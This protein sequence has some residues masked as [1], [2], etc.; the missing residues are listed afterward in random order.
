MSK[1][2]GSALMLAALALFLILNRGAYKSYFQD[3]DL[4]TMGWARGVSLP[5]FAEYLFSPRLPPA[6]FR[7][8]GALYYHVLET[9]FDLDF[10]KY[11]IPLHALHLLNVWLLWRLI[12]KLGTGTG[13][14]IAGVFFFGFHTTLIDSWWKPMYVFDVLCATFALLA[15]LLYAYDR[16]VLSLI[17][18]WLAYKSKELAVMLPAVIAC[19]ELWFGQKRWRRLLP[20]FA[21]SLLFGVQAL[22]LRS[23]EGTPYQMRLGPGA[24]ATTVAFYSSQL[25]LLP[26]AGLLLI[27]LPLFIRDR[28]LWF[29]L[30]TMCLLVAPLLLLPGRL[31]AVYWYVPLTGVAIMLASVA[32]SRY[33]MAAAVLLVLWIPWDLVHFREMRRANQLRGQQNRAYV[34]A[35]EKFARLN[36]NERLFVYDDLPDQ[37]HDWGVTGALRTIYKNNDIT[38][39]HIGQGG[40]EEL[41]QKGEA[42]WL[43][44]SRRASRLD[45]VRYSRAEPIAPYLTMDIRS[46][47]TQLL[48]GWY[49]LEDDFRWTKPDAAAVLQRPEGAR[50]FEVTACILPEQSGPEHAVSLRV[51]VDAEPIGAHEFNA[52]GCERVRWPLV[53]GHAGVVK[54]EFHSVPPY[55]PPKPDQR[56]LGIIMKGF[57]FPS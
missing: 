36:P 55:A 21:V 18:F 22:M 41:V 44:W 26:F 47:A 16:W 15:L 49:A 1:R 7:P 28:R 48:S 38:A 13:A 10:P 5:V 32:D 11:V 14:A 54:V 56:I 3:D 6:N 2:A 8:V 31:Y 23:H 40:A 57:G 4:D 39:Q 37:F 20:F 19:Y 45:A 29:G 34:Q 33:R 35:I 50:N 53:P 24:Q 25:F 30:A 43:H 9:S 52:A 17:S 51:L 42:V 12:R 46:P 27:A